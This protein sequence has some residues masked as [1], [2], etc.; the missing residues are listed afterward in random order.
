VNAIDVIEQRLRG[1]IGLDAES[2]G[3]FS[4][5]RAVQLRMHKTGIKRPDLYVSKLERDAPEWQ[6]L[7]EAVVVPETWFFRY[8]ESFR[9]LTRIAV[10]K[11]GANDEVLRILS[12]PCSTGEEPYSIAMAL[13]GIDPR[14]GWYRIDAVDVSDA[15]IHQARR[16]VFGRNSFRGRQ[17]EFRERFFTPNADRFSFNR[18]LGACVNFRQANVLAPDFAAEA[19]TYDIIFCRNLLIYFD[20]A[21]QEVLI[22]NVHRLLRSGG[23]LFVAPSESSLLLNRG[24]VATR[25]PLSFAWQKLE[26]APEKAAP[27]P[28]A[29]SSKIERRPSKK[30]RPEIGAPTLEVPAPAPLDLASARRLADDGEL[31]EARKICEQHLDGIASAEAFYLLGLLRD[32]ENDKKEAVDCYRRAVYL[33][34]DHYEALTHLALITEQIGDLRTA[35]VLQNRAQRARERSAA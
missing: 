24:F 23:H 9:A 11:Q 28:V 29:P 21:T 2:I 32:A 34:P 13:H 12:V 35:R 10:E 1:G 20:R 31:S 8:P 22:K 15:G 27:K 19:E 18:E 3:R 5:E 14:P 7:I 30:S 4:I 25:M 26:R 33:E 17:L 16:G 6:L